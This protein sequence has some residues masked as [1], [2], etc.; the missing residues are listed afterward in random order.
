MSIKKTFWVARDE[1]DDTYESPYYAIALRKSHLQ[2]KL[3]VWEILRGHIGDAMLCPIT[4]EGITGIKLEPGE[5]PV[6]VLAEFERSD[7]V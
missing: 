2:L 4:F 1:A 6:K 5:G 7:N 3:G